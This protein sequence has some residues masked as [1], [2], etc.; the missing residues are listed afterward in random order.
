M[1][2]RDRLGPF[3]KKYETLR[4]DLDRSKAEAETYEKNIERSKANLDLNIQKK[5]YDLRDKARIEEDLE[6]LKDSLISENKSFDLKNKELGEIAEKISS[7]ENDLGKAKDLK[8]SLEK[9][10]SELNTILDSQRSS[11]EEIKEQILD[12]EVFE[13]SRAII[14]Q[15]RQKDCLLY[16]SP[17]PRDRG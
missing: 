9:E 3:K 16:T 15:K 12:Y 1:C 8:I 17:S 10:I 4:E 13:K 11:A 14:D 7:L 6:N 2:I 5:D